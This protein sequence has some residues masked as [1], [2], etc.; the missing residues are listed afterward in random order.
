MNDERLDHLAAIYLHEP[1]GFWRICEANE[2]MLP[3]ALSEQVE[4]AIPE[5]D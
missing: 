2:V 1:T 4:I 5:N 3:E